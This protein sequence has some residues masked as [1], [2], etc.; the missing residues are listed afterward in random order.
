M[1][2]V[3]STR[4]LKVAA[5]MMALPIASTMAQTQPSTPSQ[6]APPEVVKPQTTLPQT[7]LPPTTPPKERQATPSGKGDGVAGAH[8]SLVGLAVMSSDGHRLGSV[9]NVSTGPDGKTVIF[10]K[11]GG[12]L[13]FGA[14]TVAIPEAK[15]TRSGEFIQLALSAQDVGKLPEAKE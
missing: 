7:T 4:V 11:T 5:I 8:N 12:F 1:T 13:G 2:V 6:T 9:H 3:L 15:F 14:H 10:L